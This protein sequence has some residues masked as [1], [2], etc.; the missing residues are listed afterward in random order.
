MGR[1]ESHHSPQQEGMRSN[2][3]RPITFLNQSVML[4]RPYR[5]VVAA[6]RSRHRP[7]RQFRRTTPRD[8]PDLGL[9]AQR[10]HG[11]LDFFRIKNKRSSDA[12]SP[13][14]SQGKRGC[15]SNGNRANGN[16]FRRSRSIFNTLRRAG[17]RRTQQRAWTKAHSSTATNAGHG[18]GYPALAAESSPRGTEQH[19]R[20]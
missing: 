16:R 9:P 1:A 12:Q 3:R 5:T 20:A 8:V 19:D 14:I 18:P 2:L 10:A 6:R 7:R 17:S 4:I 11:R 15:H 13:H